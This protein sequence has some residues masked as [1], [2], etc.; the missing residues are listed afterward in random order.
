MEKVFGIQGKNDTILLRNWLTFL[1]RQCISEHE[2]IAFHNKK[3]SQ[4]ERLIKLAYNK[5][6]KE[7]T[8]RNY[9]VLSNLHREEYFKKIFCA[10]NYLTSW[11]NEEYHILT[12]F[13]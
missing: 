4:N 1:L 10:K 7:E 2:N 12:L 13:N 8:W 11:I 9:I 3:G 5:L 6:V